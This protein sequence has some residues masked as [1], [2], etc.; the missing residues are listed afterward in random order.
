MIRRTVICLGLL[1]LT[2]LPLSAQE[3]MPSALFVNDVPIAASALI[4]STGSDVAVLVS[5]ILRATGATIKATGNYVD[6]LWSDNTGLLLEL[7]RDTCTYGGQSVPLATPCG[8]LEGDLVMPLGEL[9]AII[10]ARVEAAADGSLRVYRDVVVDSAEAYG[11][12][13]ATGQRF[14]EAGRGG[15][16]S[17]VDNANAPYERPEV[18]VGTV[19]T[20][21]YTIET[22]RSP[23]AIA[24][25]YQRPSSG[26]SMGVM[27]KQL[28]VDQFG[29]PLGMSVGMG[30]YSSGAPMTGYTAGKAIGGLGTPN[31]GNTMGGTNTSAITPGMFSP[32]NA[33][34]GMPSGLGSVSN[35]LASSESQ[36]PEGVRY[37]VAP[38]PPA[39]LALRTDGAAGDKAPGPAKI[40]ISSFDV[41]RLMSFHLTAYE[42]KVRVKNEGGMVCAHPLMLQLMAKSKRYDSYELLE[43]YVIDPLRP[44]DEVEVVKKVDGH[45][46]TCLVDLTIDFK[47]SVLE[48]KPVI[49]DKSAKINR[50][51]QEQLRRNPS[52]ESEGERS[53][54]ETCSKTKTMRF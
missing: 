26:A 43:S 52:L 33:G 16:T 3:A 51:R 6:A 42:L 41:Q 37:I 53:Y 36:T 12:S 15:L 19:G 20:S 47:V 45:Q 13:Q 23:E 49:G 30:G 4:G 44:G 5:P 21:R 2:S 35:P 38:T 7:G 11:P 8:S 14:P 34:A 39:D 9:C 54:Q 46:F 1:L 31:Y 24:S 32:A 18:S 40:S 17:K 48:S 25:A 50:E 28:A 27:G 10:G 29:I 22:P